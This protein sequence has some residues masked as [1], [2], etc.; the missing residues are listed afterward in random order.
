MNY[1]YKGQDMLYNQLFVSLH[2]AKTYSIL[3]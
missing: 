3:K 2:Y 1:K